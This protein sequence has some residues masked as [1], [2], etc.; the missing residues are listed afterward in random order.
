MSSQFYSA[1]NTPKYVPPGKRGNLPKPNADPLAQDLSKLS[2]LPSPSTMPADTFQPYGKT[3]LVWAKSDVSAAHVSGVD[4]IVKSFPEGLR[5]HFR[6][7]GCQFLLSRTMDEA[8]PHL[9]S[10]PDIGIISGV[11]RAWRELKG[12]Y[13]GKVVSIPEYFLHPKTQEWVAQMNTKGG[14]KVTRH[15]A[16][17]LLHDTSS[18]LYDFENEDVNEGFYD[19]YMEDLQ[20]LSSEQ[21]K[22]YAYAIQTDDITKPNVDGMKE[23]FAEIGATLQG[24]GSLHDSEGLQKAFPRVTE[25]LMTGIRSVIKQ[26]LKA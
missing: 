3:G 2:L 25:H 19:A 11:Q 15:E 8:F 4:K 9:K 22:K 18:L 17:H 12:M 20:K 23:A 10:G 1:Q 6:K 14:V 16:M 24:G 26:G 7:N 5:R 13:H 21:R